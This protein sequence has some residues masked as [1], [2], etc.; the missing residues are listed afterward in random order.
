MVYS[1]LTM[2]RDEAKK[3]RV[4]TDGIDSGVG[5][6]TDVMHRIE[7]SVDSLRGDFQRISTGGTPPNPSSRAK[8]NDALWTSTELFDLRDSTDQNQ[9]P[10]GS[11][12]TTPCQGAMPK[13]LESLRFEGMTERGERITTP[14]PETFGWLFMDTGFPQWLEAEDKEVYWITGKP[15]S[16]KSMLMKFI[17]T[18]PDLHNRLR[19]WAGGDAGQLLLASFFFWGPGSK[20]QKS[21]VGL[22]RSLLYQLLSQRPDLCHAVAP[23]RQVFFGLAGA[24]TAPPEWQWTELRE[25][26]LRFASEIQ[27]KARLALFVDGLD[28]YDGNHDELVAFFKQ[29]HE[30]YKPKLCVSSRPWN[31]FADEYK[32][33]PSLRMEDLTKPDIDLYIEGRLGSNLAIQELWD[34]EPDSMGMLMKEIR[35]RAEG[36]FLWVVL[37]VEQLLTTARDSPRLPVIWEVFNALPRGLEELYEAIQQSIGSSKRETASRLYQLVMERKRMWNSQMQATF[38]WVA[39]G[40][41]EPTQRVLYPELDKELLILPLITRLLAGHTRGILQVSK[42]SSSVN[43]TTVDFLHRTA[44]D[45]LRIDS[46]W[47]KIRSQGPPGFQAIITLIATLVGH[48]RSLGPPKNDSVVMKELRRQHIFRILKFAR[49]VANTAENRAQIL[50]ILDQIESEQLLPVHITFMLDETFIPVGDRPTSHGLATLAAAWACVPYL[51]AKCDASPDILRDKRRSTLAWFSKDPRSKPVSLLEA[52]VLGWLCKTKIRRFEDLH[53]HN[54]ECTYT[55]W[56]V[57]QRLDTVRFLLSKG[58]KPHDALIRL[59]EKVSVP[60]TFN[61]S[62]KG[63]CRSLEALYWVL[64]N[65]MLVN[66]SKLASF[67]ELK[68]SWLPRIEEARSAEEFS[69][70]GIFLP[71]RFFNDINLAA[72]RLPA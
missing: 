22:L 4:Q 71:S 41:V 27:G 25:C 64:V 61:G 68:R 42:H 6:L 62:T 15:A 43:C 13:V 1:M 54:T 37:V 38:L 50:T 59:V 52:S 16:G 63:S 49:D 19:T 14:Y 31:V 51:Q 24:Y 44:F 12:A 67:D 57:S 20:A 39:I 28:E 60:Q 48:L 35:D 18:H 30:Q 65:W 26:L 9:K 66:R 11:E 55:E 32:Y 45:W 56:N 7:I 21:R 34:L 29:L 53:P 69:D 8:V 72:I 3:T 46:N 58:V 17:S 47:S 36:V 70:F 23:R 40:C 2:K 10:A 33:S 5:S